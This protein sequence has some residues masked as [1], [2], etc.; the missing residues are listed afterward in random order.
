MSRTRTVS[1]AEDGQRLERLLKAWLPALSFGML[2]KWCR[3]GEVRINGK[4]VKS[5]ENVQ[6]GDEVRLPPQSVNFEGASETPEQP[7]H[8]VKAVAEWVVA[9]TEDYFVFNKPADLPSQAG[10]KQNVS[11][12]RLTA[13]H[14]PE[15]PPKLVHRLDKETTGLILMAKSTKAAKMLAESLQKRSCQK[16]YLA[17]VQGRLPAEGWVKAPVLK[18]GASGQTK[19]HIDEEGD[20][21]LTRFAVVQQTAETSLV[22][23]YPVTGRM[24]QL[25]VHMAALGHSLVADGKYGGTYKEGM[26]TFYLHAW[27]ITLPDGSS[28]RAPLPDRWQALLQEK[29]WRVPTHNPFAALLKS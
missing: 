29:E 10:S 9:E 8:L 19:M 5:N 14:W 26:K 12:D 25:R 3:K 27:E 6:A 18:S 13:A 23:L 4:R 15:N 1:K 24:H 21:A 28:Y 11:L 2:Q 7:A 20:E 16:V 22:A 17:L